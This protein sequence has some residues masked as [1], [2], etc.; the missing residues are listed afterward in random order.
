M[1]DSE[2]YKKIDE[3]YNVAVREDNKKAQI[4]LSMLLRDLAYDLGWRD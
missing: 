2:V 1:A 3:A 4:V